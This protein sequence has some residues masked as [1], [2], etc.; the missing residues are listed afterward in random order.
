MRAHTQT[1][2][3]TQDKRTC[4]CG[5]GLF[6]SF[7]CKGT[8][9]GFGFLYSNMGLALLIPSKDCRS[10]NKTELSF[11]EGNVQT[12]ILCTYTRGEKNITMR[13]CYY[14]SC[15][16]LDKITKG[17]FGLLGGGMVCPYRPFGHLFY[18]LPLF[19]NGVGLPGARE[20]LKDSQ[21]LQEMP[22]EST[23]RFKAADTLDEFTAL[24][25]RSRRELSECMHVCDYVRDCMGLY[26]GPPVRHPAFEQSIIIV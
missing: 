19:P 10:P 15:T 7:S 6:D 26:V 23:S 17:G 8:F 16:S 5:Y 20:C 18:C 21:S 22:E 9:G 12:V 11:V 2:A 13:R 25:I 1:W 14:P 24:T 4:P 3:R